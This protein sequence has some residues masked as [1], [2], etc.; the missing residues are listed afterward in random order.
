MV[1]ERA[2]EVERRLVVESRMESGSVI[3]CCHIV[4]GQ[5]LEFCGRGCRAVLEAI[6]FEGGPKG[7]H[8]GVVITVAFA[9]HALSDTAE[10]QLAAE[11]EARVLHAAV[12]MVNEGMSV[13]TF[14]LQS[15]L[16]RG[17]AQAR[18]EGVEDVPGHNLAG[19]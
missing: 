17:G 12:R 19:A 11:L 3:E 8:E 10:R 9:A 2:L 7:F 13:R 14:P 4:E 1:E 5:E 15:G 16:Q 18:F 6:G